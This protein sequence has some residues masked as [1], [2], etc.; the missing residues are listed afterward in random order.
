MSPRC[1]QDQ[2][3][4]EIVQVPEEEHIGRFSCRC[5]VGQDDL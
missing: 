1:H 2:K 5:V 3:K 4:K